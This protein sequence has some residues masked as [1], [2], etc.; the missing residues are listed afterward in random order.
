MLLNIIDLPGELLD[1]IIEI[2]LTFRDSGP[3]FSRF[4]H[5][6][7]VGNFHNKIGTQA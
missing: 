3:D 1:R 2:V 7:T 4:L 5:P 6:G